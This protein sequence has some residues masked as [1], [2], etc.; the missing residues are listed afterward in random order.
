VRATRLTKETARRQTTSGTAWATVLSF[1]QQFG[2]DAEGQAD[3]IQVVRNRV[4]NWAIGIGQRSSDRLLRLPL[5]GW[6]WRYALFKSI[7][8][9]ENLVAILPPW[10]TTAST[11][12]NQL[13]S[14]NPTVTTTPWTVALLFSRDELQLFP[15]LLLAFACPPICGQ[16]IGT[17]I[18]HP[19]SDGLSLC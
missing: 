14:S 17:A 9:T 4:S 18:L 12:T 16:L 15:T 19:I 7:G 2:L 5:E 3:R 8:P 10:N 11:L 13:P 6:S 1:R